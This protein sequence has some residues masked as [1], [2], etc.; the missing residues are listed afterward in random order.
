MTPKRKILPSM[1]GAATYRIRIR[2]H[3]D[4][5]W[6]D[7]MGGMKIVEY[8]GTG[9]SMETILQ[10]ELADQAALSGVLNALYQLHLP[11]ISARFVAKDSSERKEL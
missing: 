4:E 6:T 2:G 8:R 11:V 3:L 9:K 5:C 7:R 1:E 10:G